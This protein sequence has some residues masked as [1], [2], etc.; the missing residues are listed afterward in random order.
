MKRTVPDRPKRPVEA[1]ASNTVTNHAFRAP[2]PSRHEMQPRGPTHAGRRLVRRV[3]A[4][5]SFPARLQQSARRA[6]SCEPVEDQVFTTLLLITL[7]MTV[8]A[9]AMVAGDEG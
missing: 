8:Y 5:P 7:C 6:L 4:R 3:A 2:S 1:L 9:F